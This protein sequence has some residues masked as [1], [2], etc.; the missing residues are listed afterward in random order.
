MELIRSLI[1]EVPDFPR[2]GILFRDITPVLES[3]AALSRTIELL[4]APYVGRGIGKIVGIESRGFV[5]GAA[6]AL[7]LG[8]GLALVRKPGKLPR[9]TLSAAYTLEY[10]SGELHMHEDAVQ[11]GERVIVADDLIA[12]GGTA[13]A[14]CQLVEASGGAVA[15]VAAVV[16]LAALGGRDRLH[17]YDVQVL[18]TY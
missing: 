18:L 13:R 3:A 15:G 11:P 9:R 5:L 4:T 7:R 12:T 14:A 10:G 16:E 6:M 8:C 2:P 1:R 17:G